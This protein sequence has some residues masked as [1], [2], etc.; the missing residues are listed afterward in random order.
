MEHA[1]IHGLTE[2]AGVVAATHMA[3]LAGGSVHAVLAAGAATAKTAKSRRKE[4][5][6]EKTGGLKGFS[7][8]KANKEVTETWSGAVV[9]TGASI[10]GGVAAYAAGA[11]VGQVNLNSSD[12]PSHN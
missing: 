2:S 8:T 4:K 3:H 5:A 6:F 12:S 9:G 7:R 11:V 10:G 1:I